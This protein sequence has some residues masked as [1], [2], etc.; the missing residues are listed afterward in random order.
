MDAVDATVLRNASFLL[1]VFF[2]IFFT[3]MIFEFW[4]QE[5]DSQILFS[6]TIVFVAIICFI[7]H[8]IVQASN[9]EISSTIKWN[10]NMQFIP[11][12]FGYILTLAYFLLFFLIVLHQNQ[13]NVYHA[14]L[15][16]NLLSWG[17]ILGLGFIYV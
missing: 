12:L 8:Y 2:F 7:I 16:I 14:L 10:W 6:M 13:L 15:K 11:I 4:C 9:R 3:T 17:I 1:F 5:L